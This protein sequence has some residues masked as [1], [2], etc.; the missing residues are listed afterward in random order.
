M[1]YKQRLK[2]MPSEFKDGQTN[3][4]WWN[5]MLQSNKVYSSSEYYMVVSN[6]KYSTKKIL[7]F[8]LFFNSSVSLVDKSNLLMQHAN[9][10]F[11]DYYVY[12]N[13]SGQKTLKH[14]C[15]HFVKH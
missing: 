6:C 14:E 2:Q 1:N 7:H 12:R 15:W 13:S 3:Q 11:Y 5:W 4:A 8:T 9:F 10:D